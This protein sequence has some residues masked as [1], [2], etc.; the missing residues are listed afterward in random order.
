MYS[1]RTLSVTHHLSNPL[2]ISRT[3]QVKSEK[4]H[5]NI[6]SIWTGRE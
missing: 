6:E 5:Y 2:K 3:E 1:S 4:Y